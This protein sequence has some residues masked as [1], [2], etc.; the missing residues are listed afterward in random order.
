MQRCVWPTKSVD[1][2]IFENSIPEHLN[3]RILRIRSDTGYYPQRVVKSHKLSDHRVPYYKSNNHNWV[4]DDF[5]GDDFYYTVIY[6]T[7]VEFVYHKCQFSYYIDVVGGH[8]KDVGHNVFDRFLSAMLGVKFPPYSDIITISPH[9]I[10][11]LKAAKHEFDVD[12]HVR[13][14]SLI[15]DFDKSEYDRMVNEATDFIVRFKQ[16][17]EHM[18]AMPGYY[19]ISFRSGVCLTYW[20][21][22]EEPTLRI[23]QTID[24]NT[25]PTKA[26]VLNLLHCELAEH[27]RMA[28]R[29]TTMLQIAQKSETV[30]KHVGDDDDDEDAGIDLDENNDISDED[31]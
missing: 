18:N 16:M 29:I 22:D 6:T 17:V 31:E 30:A 27:L 14:D 2:N 3:A 1:I 23:H 9:N 12:V 28:R 10:A 24:N 26:D 11:L 7:G 20:A 4:S 13:S 8:K 19:C 15:T 5:G 21:F 25:S